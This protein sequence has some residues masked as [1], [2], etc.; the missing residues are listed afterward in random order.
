[1]GRGGIGGGPP[2]AD[3]AA[4]EC[5][6]ARPR[7]RGREGPGALARTVCL[8]RL[9]EGYA[10]GAIGTKRGSRGVAER[11]SGGAIPALA[12]SFKKKISASMSVFLRPGF[13]MLVE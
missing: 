12:S 5:A 11:G 2:A 4:H 6:G 3:F 1:R 7:R 8:T 9:P 13:A 10:R